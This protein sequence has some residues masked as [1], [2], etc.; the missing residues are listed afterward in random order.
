M[1]KQKKFQFLHFISSLFHFK[2]CLIFSFVVTD[3]VHGNANVFA[4]FREKITIKI[5]RD[6]S[7]KGFVN[8]VSFSH[9]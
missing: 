6:Q 4:K 1:H 2:L 3:Y 8:P 5:I 7:F 9:L